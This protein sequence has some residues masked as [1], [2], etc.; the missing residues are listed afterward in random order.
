VI[1]VTQRELYRLKEL[2]VLNRLRAGLDDPFNRFVK[3]QYEYNHIKKL[4]CKLF[5]NRK[6]IS[7]V[8]SETEEKNS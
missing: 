8:V 2:L 7:R 6:M 3:Q 1:Y 4:S 5:I